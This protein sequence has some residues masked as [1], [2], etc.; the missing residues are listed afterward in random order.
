MDST[1]YAA[2]LSSIGWLPADPVCALVLLVQGSMPTAQNLVLLLQLRESTR[3]LAPRMAALLVRLY[4]IAILPITAWI[5][6]FMTRLSL[7]LA[8]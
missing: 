8:T 6:L 3:P 1:M 2:G 7:G 5:A 4:A